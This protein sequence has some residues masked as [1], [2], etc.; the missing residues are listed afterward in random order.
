MLSWNSGGSVLT[1]LM[2]RVHV[3]PRFQA[4]SNVVFQTRLVTIAINVTLFPL[5]NGNT[6]TM[7]KDVVL[8]SSSL[9]NSCYLHFLFISK[10]HFW[11][12][13]LCIHV[14]IPKRTQDSGR[15]T[16][17]QC[18]FRYSHLS[19]LYELAFCQEQS[20]EVEQLPCA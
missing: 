8:I 19:L 9:T 18:F 7:L 20:S 1:L 12:S 5:L 14:A 13:Q 2:A 16:R 15:T 11:V 17:N 3:E 10:N 4:K 6:H